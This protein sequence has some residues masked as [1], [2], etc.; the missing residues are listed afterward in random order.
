MFK[1]SQ[2]LEFNISTR[3]SINAFV[4]DFV[5]WDFPFCFEI[6][7]SVLVLVSICF[8]FLSPI[9]SYLETAFSAVAISRLSSSRVLFIAETVPLNPDPLE[10]SLK[11]DVRLDKTR[12]LSLPRM[13]QRAVSRLSPPSS[14]S[15]R[16]TSINT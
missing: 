10:D 15:K 7:V 5:L 6:R 8:G 11:F 1:I 2:I 9:V 4:L 12:F 13:L 3:Q 16:V 14:P